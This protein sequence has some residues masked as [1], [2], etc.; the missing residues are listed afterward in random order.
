[1]PALP[2]LAW[3]QYFGMPG[4]SLPWNAVFPIA[5]YFTPLLIGFGFL[6]S[7]EISF[8]IWFF[9][10]LYKVEA[11]IMASF[12]YS[13]ADVP[14]PQ[15]QSIGSFLLLGVA[16]LWGERTTFGQAFRELFARERAPLAIRTRPSGCAGRCWG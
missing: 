5:F 15:E 14:F 16:L 11:L 1:M 10:V 13:V 12:G 4:A 3:Y 6:V 9:Y 7:A 8:S 2:G